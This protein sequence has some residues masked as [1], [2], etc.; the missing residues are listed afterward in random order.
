M[1]GVFFS[2]PVFVSENVGIKKTEVTFIIS[3]VKKSTGA[4]SKTNFLIE[5]LEYSDLFLMPFYAPGLFVFF[6]FK[7]M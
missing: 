3:V 1:H 4:I 6:V 7:N 2:K 5:W